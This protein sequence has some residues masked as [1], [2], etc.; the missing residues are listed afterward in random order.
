LNAALHFRFISKEKAGKAGV[1]VAALPGATACKH[2]KERRERQGSYTTREALYSQSGERF[3]W[4]FEKTPKENLA[5]GFDPSH[6]GDRSKYYSSRCIEKFCSTLAS[7]SKGM[8]VFRASF[9][10]DT[11]THCNVLLCLLFCILIF[12][13]FVTV[14]DRFK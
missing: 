1:G 10:L 9:L 11:R 3:L 13:L 4:A 6:S 7:I 5:S 14:F 2:W 8:K 12:E